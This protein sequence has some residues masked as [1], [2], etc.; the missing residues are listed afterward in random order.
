M[1]WLLLPTKDCKC[2]TCEKAREVVD[3][4]GNVRLDPSFNAFKCVIC[5]GAGTCTHCHPARR[6]EEPTGENTACNLPRGH[7]GM[8]RPGEVG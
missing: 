6:C 1:T 4:D 8:H 7:D 2:A 3:E 5:G